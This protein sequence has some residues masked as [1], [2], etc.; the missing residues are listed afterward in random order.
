MSKNS[1][2]N[3]GETMSHSKSE[4]KKI[5]RRTFLKYAA[6]V[7]ATGVVV[8]T[9]TYFAVPK[10]VVETVKTVTV[11]GTTVTT[12]K[13][14]TET[15]TVTPIV[16]PTTSIVTTTPT[17]TVT[18]PAGLREHVLYTWEGAEG[19][20]VSNAAKYWNEHYAKKYGFTVKVS[21]WGREE[22]FSKMVN[23][24]TSNTDTWQA[25]M[26]FNFYIPSFVESGSLAPLSDYFKDPEYFL[27]E[28]T[29]PLKVAVDLASYK[30]EI[31]G[32]SQVIVSEGILRYRKDLI[33]RLLKD[34]AWQ[35][36]YKSL[37]KEHLGMELDPKNPD[38]WNWN[39]YLA[40]A[41]FFTKK[42]N[43]DSPTDYGT[44]FEGLS[45]FGVQFAAYWYEI[46]ESF[47]GTLF[48]DGKVA[49]NSPEG[50]ESLKY[51][52]DLRRKWEVVPPDVHRYEA[53]EEY[54]AF[55]SGKVAFG[56]DWDWDTLHLLNPKESPLVYDK[57]EETIPP[58]GPG[59][60]CAYVQQFAW[61]INEHTSEQAKKD[62]ARFLMWA[63]HSKEGV[64]TT[65]KAGIPAGTY[66]PEILTTDYGFSNEEIKHYKFYY[67]KIL[68]G[69]VVRPV[70]WPLVPTA[71]DIYT[72]I[73]NILGMAL[74][75]EVS[76]EDALKMMEDKLKAL[77]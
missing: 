13:T 37:A 58:K 10:G 44:V 16:S 35:S 8:G 20:A 68:S 4:T 56:L 48:K 70:Y 6:A 30:G 73:S 53:F 45:A 17:P 2:K 3:R 1:E 23:M 52:L 11:P 29:K 9:A 60:R 28:Y 22:F 72:N 59:G 18:T 31:Y 69:T 41:L 47:G 71:P 76:Y 7:A 27:P 12:T 67:E 63:S 38:E 50:L 74:A 64:L 34:S 57:M 62:M 24:I 5:D 55:Q 19:T 25:Y 61:V 33:E 66:I 40:T 21:Q 15:V 51:L 42:Y 43:P 32:S 75:G 77:I 36:K 46:L 14:V 54:T 49:V 26:V 39:D 65:L